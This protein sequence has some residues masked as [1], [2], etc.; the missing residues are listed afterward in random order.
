MRTTRTLLAA[1]SAGDQRLRAEIYPHYAVVRRPD[2]PLV[3][4]DHVD[5]A[6][7]V[8]PLVRE[9]QN[10][11]AGCTA[12]G[13]PDGACGC[14]WNELRSRGIATGHQLARLGSDL[15]SSDMPAYLEQ[16]MAACAPT[17]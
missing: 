7:R 3:F 12:G 5:G 2:A 6:W 8:D 14:V 13:A 16:A 17:R 10:F 11:M 15:G 4:L 1:G 9:E